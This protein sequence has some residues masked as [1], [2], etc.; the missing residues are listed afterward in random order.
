MLV[1]RQPAELERHPACGISGYAC[2]LV[3]MDLLEVCSD[4]FLVKLPK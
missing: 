3:L 4:N 1:E 2:R